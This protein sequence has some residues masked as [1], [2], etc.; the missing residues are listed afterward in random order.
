MMIR[1]KFFEYHQEEEQ[2]HQDKLIFVDRSDQLKNFILEALNVSRDGLSFEGICTWVTEEFSQI[3]NK[4]Y[5]HHRL[6]LMHQ[7]SDIQE[8]Q[9]GNKQIFKPF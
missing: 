6:D 1:E 8:I 9:V 3:L 2:Q 7:N 4:E 5:I